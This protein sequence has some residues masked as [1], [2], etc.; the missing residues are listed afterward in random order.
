VQVPSQHSEHRTQTDYDVGGTGEVHTLLTLPEQRRSRQHS[1]TDPIVEHSPHL[2]PTDNRTSIA[3]PSNLEPR[4]AAVAPEASSRGGAGLMV[5]L[6]KQSSTEGLR[7]PDRAH[8]PTSK[9][10][11]DNPSTSQQGASVLG[12]SYGVNPL[13]QPLQPPRRITSHRS[14]RRA[15]SGAS[16]GSAGLLGGRTYTDAGQPPTT[17][18]SQS[19]AERGLAQ[20]DG[21]HDDD[22]A[23]ELAWGPSHPC[24]PHLNPH[25]PINS[26]EYS[27]TRI[28]RVRRDWM[29]AG[30]LAP[31]FS[32]IYPEI[33][34][35]L[36]QEGEF[37]YVIEHINQ[38]LCQAYDPFSAWNW[39][40]GIM[41]VLTGWFW[42]DFRPWG[43]KGA[44]KGLEE[45][46]ED[47][48]HTVGA[49]DG[50]RLIPLRRTGYM[51]LDVQIPDPQ[52]RVVGE[53]ESQARPNTDGTG[54]ADHQR[55]HP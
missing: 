43:I 33:L 46:L 5:D 31:T 41:G 15:Q 30:D 7:Q 12:S 11:A 1:P 29:V 40:D 2:T 4:G 13:D 18:A 44:L 36:M 42:E 22:V 39:F 19:D 26:R 10:N 47:W 51:C 28:I 48:N 32:N 24:F 6:E 21:H 23:E 53:D 20:H 50:V 55:D 34:D 17:G 35:P 9:Y 45:W 52:V 38:T 8:I 37:R 27:A 16:I 3:L 14:L 25:V 54:A 49:R